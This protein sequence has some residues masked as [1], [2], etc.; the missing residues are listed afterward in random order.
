MSRL[1]PKWQN[2]L[3]HLIAAQIAARLCPGTRRCIRG[4]LALGLRPETIALKAELLGPVAGWRVGAYLRYL[5]G[6]T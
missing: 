3:D 5:G 4:L 2:R 1:P 6:K